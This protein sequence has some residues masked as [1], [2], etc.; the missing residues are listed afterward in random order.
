[1]ATP[2]TG[3]VLHGAGGDVVDSK[4]L[5]QSV[6]LLKLNESLL[7]DIKQA[8][9][10][11]G[12][13]HFITGNPPKIRLGKRTIDLSISSEAFRHELYLASVE[14]ANDFHFKSLISHTV[15]WKLPERKHSL[16]SDAALA[17]LQNS[18]ASYEQ[19]KQAKSTNITN[20]ILPA[21]KSR[22][23]AAR[24]QK[25]NAR[26]G[27]LG[28]QGP[29]PAMNHT[30]AAKSTPTSSSAVA[31]ESINKSR[32]MRVP[33][34]HLL[35][36][37]PLSRNEILETTHIPKDD[38]DNILGKIAKQANGKWQLTDRAFKEL[39]A[40][41]FGYAS[42]EDRQAA[43]DN[44]I[45]AYDRMRLGKDEK[46]WQMLLP[47]DQRDKGIVLSKLHLGA[48]GSM[49]RALT[50]LHAPIHASS[51]N[52]HAEKASDPNN[53]SAA[54]TPQ[55]G[56]SPV[57]KPGH[58]RSESGAAL[59]K[60]LF[61]KDPKKTR[62]AEEA[63]EKKRKERDAAATGSDKESGKPAKK[64]QVTQAN[65]PKIKSAE[66]VHSS[67]DETGEE[68][69][70]KGIEHPSSQTKAVANGNR[71]ANSDAT[72]KPNPRSGISP[73]EKNV[74]SQTARR[75]PTA[76][77][78]PKTGTLSAASTPPSTTKQTKP[79]RVAKG[80]T[81]GPP[82]P[83]S[84]PKSQQSPPKPNSGDSTRP[85]IPSPLGA[86]RPRVT[87]D[88]SDK[89]GL[90]TQ[91]MKHGAETPKGL[92]TTNGIQKRQGTAKSTTTSVPSTSS[93]N[94]STE[95]KTATEKPAQSGV[96]GTSTPKAPDTNS[97]NSRPTT[98]TKRTIS[99]NMDPQSQKPFTA[100]H[101]KTDSTLSLSQ[102]PTSSPF[103]ATSGTNGRL[104]RSGGS[105]SGSDSQSSILNDISYSQG[106]TLAQRFQD[107]YYP[108]Y[109]KMYDEQAAKETRG[110]KVAKEER[111]RLWAMHRR[112]EQIKREI[113]AA[114]QRGHLED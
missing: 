76:G 22:F 30:H 92:P 85:T 21:P 79:V 47:R 73:P 109:A 65:N 3:I 15:E 95:N 71:V 67:D 12:G 81:N 33:V 41:E 52:P 4:I 78:T 94:L 13:L 40:W 110:E 19:E 108:R 58:S 48:G 50:P 74:A 1:M 66:F 44:A 64:R 27:L 80:T 34:L 35:A 7:Q 91:R 51:P 100:K 31:N 63:K 113:K 103:E 112:L 84:Q 43:V 16:G 23:Q 24:T 32:A 2:A 59:S 14:S 87:S 93:K 69:A 42:Q 104:E 101:R 96:N 99:E 106:I 88:V 75:K 105:T 46:L 6:V 18:L 77:A 68:S 90:N 102:M 49:A 38:L 60:R 53:A 29:N 37:G 54:N 72:A 55:V 10:E 111:D 57:P 82:A 9:N 8:S 25:L 83:I 11:P 70:G 56:V 114:S 26:K 61:S 36:M 62:A 20:S 45:K 28:S 5:P 97:T 98:G 86:A 89:G 17:A 39:D 107:E